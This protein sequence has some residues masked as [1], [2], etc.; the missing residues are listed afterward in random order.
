ML[1]PAA[2]TK[3][4]CIDPLTGRSIA[5]GSHRI[6]TVL[7]GMWLLFPE[8]GT[9]P[10]VLVCGGRQMHD[11][12]QMLYLTVLDAHSV[13]VCSQGHGRDSPELEAESK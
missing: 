3:L 2:I 6:F 13:Q 1:V 7:S 9:L 10:C 4:I 12:R 8:S 5:E 11:L